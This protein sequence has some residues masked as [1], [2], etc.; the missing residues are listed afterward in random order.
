MG[1]LE[2]LLHNEEYGSSATSYWSPELAPASATATATSRQ[3]T[4]ARYGQGNDAKKGSRDVSAHPELMVVAKVTD[5]VGGKL[6]DEK[7]EE[8]Q[9]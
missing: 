5:M 7:S 1:A 9:P 2:P 6:S 4:I 3:D 8:H